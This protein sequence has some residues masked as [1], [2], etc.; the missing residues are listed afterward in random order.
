VVVSHDR[1]FMNRVVT[2]TVEV[3]LRALL[4]YPGDYDAYLEAKAR[5]GG[6]PDGSPEAAPPRTRPLDGGRG[7]PPVAGPKTR[8]QKRA[9]AEAR[10]RRSRETGPHRRRLA[11]VEAAIDSLEERLAGLSETQA[12]PGAYRDAER[13]RA[14][15]A[16]RSGLEGRLAALY[17]EWS[18]LGEVIARL[19]SG[20]PGPE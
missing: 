4:R 12:D 9:E 20:E 2:E 19:E 15:A 3:G 5:E 8:E 1:Y 10:Q 6:G 16:E 18:E 17:E 13:A 7:F 11:E 14:L